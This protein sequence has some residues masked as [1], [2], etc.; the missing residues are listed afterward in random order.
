MEEVK[1]ED[2][3]SSV[4]YEKLEKEINCPNCNK[5]IDYVGNYCD[6]CGQ[7]LKEITANDSL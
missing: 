5:V 7:N 1:K 3:P 6:M 2:S 4:E